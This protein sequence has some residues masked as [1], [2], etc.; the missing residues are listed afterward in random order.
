MHVYKCVMRGIEKSVLELSEGRRGI[1]YGLT[2]NSDRLI[3]HDRS[4]SSLGLVYDADTVVNVVV[5]LPTLS[6][7]KK[8]LKLVSNEHLKETRVEFR[9]GPLSN[10][11]VKTI[12]FSGN[13]EESIKEAE[14]IAI[15]DICNG[16]FQVRLGDLS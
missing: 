15:V 10:S 3:V 13:R 8:F 14:S 16:R 12:R 1:S 2:L 11:W 6:A 4:P 9:T 5:P 7:R